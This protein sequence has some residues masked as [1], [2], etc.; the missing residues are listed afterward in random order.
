MPCTGT[1]RSASGSA[2]RPVPTPNSSAAPSPAS[3]ATR[4]TTGPTRS[5]ANI[6]A[7]NRSYRRAC[8]SSNQFLGTRR[9]LAPCRS[10]DHRISTVG[11]RTPT[12]RGG[13]MTGYPSPLPAAGH[14]EPVPRRIRGVL[15]GRTVLDTL[16]ARYVWESV[17]YPQYY[18]PLTDVAAD[19]LVDERHEQKLR[20]GRA[21]RHG[22]AVGD[23]TR[24]G[25]VRVYD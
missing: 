25:A 21:H 2:I 14:H 16:A 5:G 1:P 23:V 8:G 3:S 7:S 24:P 9:T 22:L 11:D 18:V 12:T 19:V 10:A 4:S 20:F 15:A 17:K 6:A 13:P